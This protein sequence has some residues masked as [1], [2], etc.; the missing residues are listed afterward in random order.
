[1]KQPLKPINEDIKLLLQAETHDEL[2]VVIQVP[3]ELFVV[4]G[5]RFVW[6]LS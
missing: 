2:E 6:G 5:K 1:M 3:H 4:A